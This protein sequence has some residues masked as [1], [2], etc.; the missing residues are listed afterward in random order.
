[1]S[2]EML[3]RIGFDLEETRRVLADEARRRGNGDARVCECGHPMARHHAAEWKGEGKTECKPSR[4]ICSCNQARAVIRVSD[5]RRFLRRTSGA[6][7]RHALMKGLAQL[8]DAQGT[9]TWLTDLEDC[10][11]CGNDEGPLTIVPIGADGRGGLRYNSE[12]ALLSKFLCSTCSTRFG[13]V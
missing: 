1:M 13:V 12:S 7:P 2:D 11:K 10:E 5:T 9:W 3:A 4:L 6:G 8:V